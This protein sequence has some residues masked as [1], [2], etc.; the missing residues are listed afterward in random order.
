MP[1]HVKG[2]TVK[3][4]NGDYNI[5]LNSDI[6]DEKRVNAFRHELEHIKHGHFYSYSDVV[7]LEFAV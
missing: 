3:D 1:L 7:S 4:E 6:P 2:L 5:Y